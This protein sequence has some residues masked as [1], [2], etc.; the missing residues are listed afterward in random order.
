MK[1]TAGLNRFPLGVG[2]VELVG[3]DPEREYRRTGFANP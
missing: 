1:C 2:R 3:V